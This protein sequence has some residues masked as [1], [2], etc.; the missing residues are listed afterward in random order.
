MLYFYLLDQVEF[1]EIIRPALSTSWQRRS[2]LPCREICQKLISRVTAFVPGHHLAGDEPLLL[3]VVHEI[4]FDRRL[5]HHLVGEVLMY[6]AVEVPRIETAADTLCCLLAPD[7]IREEFTTR[8]RFA[9]IQQAHFGT[10]DLVFGDG[11]YRPDF[12]GWNDPD[13]VARLRDYFAAQDPSQWNIATL[14]PLPHLASDAERTEELEYAREWFAP[15]GDLY[16][17]ACSARQIIVC[18]VLGE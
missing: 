1:L 17:K 2:F 12:A 11:Y 3:Q 5:W 7:R 10:R 9:P 8:D 18:E 13:D 16:R 15:L 4:N 6:S 14:E